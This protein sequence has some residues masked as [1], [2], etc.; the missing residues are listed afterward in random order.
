MQSQSQNTELYRN[1]LDN[2]HACINYL[3]GSHKINNNF[4]VRVVLEP[5]NE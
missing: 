5:Y 2:F 1:N 4:K 3:T